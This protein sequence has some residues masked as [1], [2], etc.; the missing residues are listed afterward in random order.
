[1]TY[2]EMVTWVD[3]G[4][5]IY[6]FWSMQMVILLSS[7]KLKELHFAGLEFQLFFGVFFSVCSGILGASESRRRIQKPFID[8]TQ[9][10]CKFVLFLNQ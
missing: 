8:Q 4:Y 5:V 2:M 7:V 9:Y 1:M 6:I 10:C 3:L